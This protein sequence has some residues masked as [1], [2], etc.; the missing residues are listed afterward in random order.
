MAMDE[1]AF[2]RI[3]EKDELIMREVM[4]RVFKEVEQNTRVDNERALEAISAIGIEKLEV[5]TDELVEWQ[6]MADLSVRNLIQSGEISEQ[7]VLL[8]LTT[9]QDY[10]REGGSD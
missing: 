9:L 3:D 6:S 1:K 7:S 2:K 8:Y 4:N 5:S 10:R